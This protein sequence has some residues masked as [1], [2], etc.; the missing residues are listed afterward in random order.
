MIFTC[1]S[2][3][4]FSN[5]EKNDQV[6][7]FKLLK[8][9]YGNLTSSILVCKDFAYLS[10]SKKRITIVDVGCAIGDFVKFFDIINHNKPPFLKYEAFGIDPIISIY[11]SRGNHY[12][13]Y[14]KLYGG[15]LSE[16]NGIV[17]INVNK[18]FPDF[19]SIKSIDLDVIN[20]VFRERGSTITFDEECTY[21]L[22]CTSITLDCFCK[23]ENINQIDILKLD[24]QGNEFEILKSISKEL[25]S[26]VGVIYVETSVPNMK[27]LYKKQV[28][29]EEIYR[30]MQQNNF[31]F[32]GAFGLDDVITL[33]NSIDINC[34]FVNKR[35]TSKF[36]N[37]K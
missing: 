2:T 9:K 20:D 8:E 10:A 18:L 37:N 5:L 24:T 29:F 15:V 31:E 23:N 7:Y 22:A 25:L 1:F 16:I 26:Q 6:N 11:S 28:P 14:K 33:E 12:S 34:I 30:L 3:H 17:E 36:K 32:I 13:L 21:K 35:I 4:V 19:S 27:C